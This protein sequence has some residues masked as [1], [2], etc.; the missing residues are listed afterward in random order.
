MDNLANIWT[1]GL[2]FLQ[3]YPWLQAF[4]VIIIFS[5]LAWLA[6]RV[7][8][9]II[10]R[11]VSKTRTNVDDQLVNILHR[12]V[13]SSVAMIG[14]VLATYRIDLAEPL[15]VSVVAII[16]SLLILIWLIFGLRLSRI[17]L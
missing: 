10:T 7:I 3:P 2:E 16:K 17:I 13:F 1:N 4:G 11:L 12:P 8:S 9:G 14:L 15:Q 5:V 6:D